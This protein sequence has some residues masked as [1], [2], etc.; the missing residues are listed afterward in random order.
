[1]CCFKDQKDQL[2]KWPDSDTRK[3][4]WEEE[5][6]SLCDLVTKDRTLEIGFEAFLGNSDSVRRQY[7]LLLI[8]KAQVSIPGSFWGPEKLGLMNILEV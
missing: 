1:M 5:S 7:L 4:Y 8:R 2:L 6:L 3:D